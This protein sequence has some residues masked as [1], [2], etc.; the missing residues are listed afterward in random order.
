MRRGVASLSAALPEPSGQENADDEQ[1]K[2]TL[3]QADGRFRDDPEGL[4]HS[5]QY[6]ETAK[7]KTEHN[8]ADVP[9][10]GTSR[11]HGRRPAPAQKA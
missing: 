10:G 9:V 11:Q 4:Q 6:G 5:R 3:A 2:I 8:H 1:G 7:Y